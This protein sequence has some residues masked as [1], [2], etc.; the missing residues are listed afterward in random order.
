MPYRTPKGHS[1]TPGWV[2]KSPRGRMAKANTMNPDTYGNI[3]P[4]VNAM[5]HTIGTLLDNTQCNK[6]FHDK[7]FVGSSRK[8]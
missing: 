8:L 4:G 2:E 6:Q 3:L 5:V 7:D 1:H